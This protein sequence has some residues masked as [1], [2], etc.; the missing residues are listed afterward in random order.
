M[1]NQHVFDRAVALLNE[2]VDVYLGVE[3]IPFWSSERR[4]TGKDRR[5]YRR[6]AGRLRRG[7]QKAALKHLDAYLALEPNA[8]DAET[9]RKFADRLRTGK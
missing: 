9:V 1:K 4:T 6:M 7:E 8:P 2:L 5:L 3:K